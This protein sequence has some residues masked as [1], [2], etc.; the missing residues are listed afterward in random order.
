MKYIYLSIL[1]LSGILHSNNAFAQESTETFLLKFFNNR[2]EVISPKKIR[3]GMGIIIEN[4][5]LLDL[6]GQLVTGERKILNSFN[7]KPGKFKTIVLSS[8]FDKRLYVVLQSPPIQEVELIEGKNFYE[9][10]SQK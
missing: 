8:D 10:P 6:R 7:I 1:I 5:T 2:V 4:D 3:N 9:I